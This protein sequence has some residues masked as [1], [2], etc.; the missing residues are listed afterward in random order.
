MHILAAGFGTTVAMWAVGYVCRLP[1]AAVPGGVVAVGLLLC[2][3]AG[4]YVVGRHARA[5]DVGAAGALVGVVS[6]ILNLLILGSLLTGDEPNALRPTALLWIPGSIAASALITG[7]GAWLGGRA[8]GRTLEPSTWRCGFVLAVATAT[9]LVVVAGGLVTSMEAGLAVPDWPN[10]FGSNMFLYPLARMTGGIY[11]EHAHRLYGSLVGLST[12]ALALVLVFTDRRRWLWGMGG[13]LVIMVIGQGIMGGLRVTGEFTMSA[14]PASTPNL[15]L[16]IVHGVF[17]QVFFACVGLAW[18]FTTVAWQRGAPAE[19]E[20]DV[21]GDRSLSLAVLVATLLQIVLGAL[22]RH[23]LTPENLLPWPAAAHFAMAALVAVLG[24]V[25]GLRAWAF[26]GDRPALRPL[27]LTLLIVLS[28]Q[29]V[30]GM[31]ALVPVMAQRA[32]WRAVEV[33]L[34]TAHQANG[35]IMLVVVTQLVAWT[36]LRVRC[37]AAVAPAAHSTGASAGLSASSSASSA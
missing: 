36:R 7:V 15:S 12:I 31:A 10:T 27:G 9:L 2:L 33:I 14:D 5:G 24:Y 4:G 11:Y 1:V 21:G 13:L 23:T 26:H 29:L 18:A 6:A 19:A 35:A 8:P 20:R 37:P 34:A 3:L 25:L 32:E 22:Y 16:A 30:L 17:G 28:L